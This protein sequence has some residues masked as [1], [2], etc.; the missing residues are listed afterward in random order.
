[1]GAKLAAKDAR[2]DALLVQVRELTAQVREIVLRLSKDSSTSSR[3][4]SS[5][6]PGGRPKSN[7]SRRK[8]DRNHGKQS[9]NPATPLRE[10]EV[11][12]H[13]TAILAPASCQGWA[14]L[15]AGV[16]AVGVRW[17]QVFDLPKPA[18]VEVTKCAAATKYCPGCGARAS[19]AF[20]HSGVRSPVGAQGHYQGRLRGLGHHLPIH[21]P[22]LLV[23]ALCG[24]KVSTRFAAC[25]RGRAAR[26]LGDI[27][28][29]TLR[30]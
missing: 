4:P 14:T 2:I 21:R 19:G 23:I 25:L 22:T 9:K 5:D 17:R 12:D 27:S 20:P 26:L 29:P 10:V 6:G 24:L 28:L 8:P 7:S 18:P 15:L 30:A 11:G 16:P 1:M 13:R 3:P